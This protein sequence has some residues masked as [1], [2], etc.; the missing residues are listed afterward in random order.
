MKVVH[1]QINFIVIIKYVLMQI[2]LVMDK[3]IVGILVMKIGV[4]SIS[5]KIYV[6]FFYIVNNVCVNFI[7]Y[8]ENLSSMNV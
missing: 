2:L 3:M 8:F 7:L 5:F 6:C 1:G 4:V